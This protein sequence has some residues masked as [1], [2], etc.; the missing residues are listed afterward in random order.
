MQLHGKAA[1]KMKEF[2]RDFR[3][4][5]S[6][7]AFQSE[8]GSGSD[9]DANTD[10]F[11]WVHDRGNIE[12]GRVSG[13]FPEN[14]PGYLRH[15]REF[16]D[17]A[18]FIGLD[19]ARLSIEWSR[20]FPDGPLIGPAC[21]HDG[22]SITSVEIEAAQLEELDAQVDRQALNKYTEIFED[23]RSRNISLI[24]NLYHWTLPL[25]L[26][27][28]VRSRDH[29]PGASPSGWL[30]RDIV[31]QF[32]LFAAYSAS[33]FDDFVVAYSTMNEPNVLYPKFPPGY[34]GGDVPK[35]VESSLIQ[36]HARAY[37]S[38]K[39]VSEKPVGIISGAPSYMPESR[40]DE[41]AA[42]QAQEER[43]WPFFDALT[44]GK[45]GL[46]YRDDLKGRLDW[47][48]LNY[49]CRNVIHRTDT[50]YAETEGYG[51]RCQRNSKSRAGL[52]TSD[53]GWE[54]YPEGI[55]EVLE[56]FWNRYHIPLWV[57][58]NGIADEK[59]KLRS[60][61]IA[62]HL[63]QVLKALEAGVDVRGYLYWSLVD[64]YEWADGFSAKFGLSSFD[65]GTCRLERRPSSMALKEIIRRRDVSGEAERFLNVPPEAP[66]DR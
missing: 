34:F 57:S 61:F 8:M 65:R 53:F 32:A 40:E 16:H 51:R 1:V 60:Y 25:W 39:S 2:P 46:E 30:S 31:G 45:K 21:R 17:E 47:I 64:N 66:H 62:S 19:T 37:D 10:W 11:S 33:K 29:G 5:W 38:I 59:D 18:S 3:F 54:I 36:A 12:A 56:S 22:E 41:E 28:P 23:L 24:L 63:A 4:G 42:R 50:G 55:S 7:S 52:Q 15:F 44:S 27:D 58:E 14:G 6:Q 43:R 13:D 48:G 20:L 49:Y 26:H 35:R 9:V